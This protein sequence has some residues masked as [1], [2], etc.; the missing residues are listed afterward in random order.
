MEKVYQAGDYEAVHQNPVWRDKAN[1]IIAAY[2]G[3]KEGR[4]EWEQLWALRLDERC[5]SI[6]CIPFFAY[7]LAL[8]DEVE[9]DG[10]HV[11][12]RVV[13]ASGRYT[14]RVWFE[15]SP[16]LGIKDEVL[17][18]IGRVGV[19]FEWSSENLL[20]VSAGDADQAQ[21]MA[22]YLHAQQS[23]GELTYET[24]RAA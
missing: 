10:N 17:L 1:F 14:F 5:F 12:Q 20:A 19:D 15:N 18:Q 6:C 13:K 11:V 4:S 24:G 22:D 2:L 3:D 8:G 21:Q 7:D 23:T 16:R 9:T